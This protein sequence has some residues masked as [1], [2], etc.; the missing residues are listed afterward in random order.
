MSIVD[1]DQDN[2][3]QDVDVEEPD[4]SPFPAERRFWFRFDD[5][6]F[7]SSH[8]FAVRLPWIDIGGESFSAEWQQ[9][10]AKELHLRA[11][12]RGWGFS[13]ASPRE[14]SNAGDTATYAYDD[15]HLDRRYV[16][17]IVALWPDAE[18]RFALERLGAVLFFAAG[19]LVG[20]VMP[21]RSEPFWMPPKWISE[22]KAT[23]ARM[24]RVAAVARDFASEL[25]E[26]A[27]RTV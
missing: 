27:K 14:L 12:G 1:D 7:A 23:R 21:V 26:S 25:S 9:R 13:C 6:T 18:P 10:D 4:N 24:V 5:A 3:D 11:D 8:C 2:N 19:K 17:A 22:M 15:Q 20:I 16:D